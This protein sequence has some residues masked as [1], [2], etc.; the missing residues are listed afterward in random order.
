M[1]GDTPFRAA[2][3]EPVG[4]RAILVRMLTN[5]RVVYSRQSDAGGL[6]WVLRLRLAIPGAAAADRAEL[7]RSLAAIG[8]FGDAARELDVLAD[9]DAGGDEAGELR[10]QAT[11]LRA[12]LN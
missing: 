10:R 3:L 2:F 6:A 12:R 7:A 1:G 11:V 5:L 9:A 8:R 4:A